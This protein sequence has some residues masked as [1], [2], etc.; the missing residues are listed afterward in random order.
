MKILT[1]ILITFVFAFLT[2]ALYELSFI[3]A[4]PVRYCL[5]LLLIVL[6]LVAGFSYIVWT[7][8]QILKNI[9]SNQPKK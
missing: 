5:V 7:M 8:K 6:E 3:S 2:S 1:A 4:N 9:N